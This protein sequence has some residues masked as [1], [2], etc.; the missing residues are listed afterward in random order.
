MDTWVPCGPVSNSCDPLT[1]KKGHQWLGFWKLQTVTDGLYG[2]GPVE[3]TTRHSQSLRVDREEERE[4]TR[5]H[6]GLTGYPPQ[7]PETAH[8][9]TTFDVFTTSHIIMQR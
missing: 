3:S 6:S 7:W 1:K 8:G 9:T 4:E 2:F 5:V